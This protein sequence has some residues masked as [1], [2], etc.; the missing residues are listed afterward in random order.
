MFGALR[1]GAPPKP[2]QP[3][4]FLGAVTL[5]VR[6]KQTKVQGYK[7]KAGTGSTT[8]AKTQKANLGITACSSEY[9]EAGR[10]IVKQR[11]FITRNPF[12]NKRRHDKMYPGVNVW[13]DKSTSLRSSVSGRVK[14]TWDVSRK[15]FIANVLAEPREELLREDTWRYRTEFVDSLEDNNHVCLLRSKAILAFGKKWVNLP[16]GPRPAK[17]TINTTY[18][19]WNNP[20][21]RDP[22]DFEPF[23]FSLSGNLLRRHLEQVKR[24]LN[25][26]ENPDPNFT[27]EDRR[28]QE[29]FRGQS[30][31]R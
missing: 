3:S 2:A 22:L 4:S 15:V 26:E 11:K 5:S 6:N 1:L 18:D 8:K 7:N 23:K 20:Y 12:S 10:R 27:I 16:E 19:K 25:G 28:Y 21:Q 17:K 31:Q 13:V 14:M 24:R 9:V 29:E 30:A